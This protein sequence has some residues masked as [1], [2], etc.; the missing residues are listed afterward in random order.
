MLGGGVSACRPPPPDA[1]APLS[2]QRFLATK[3]EKEALETSLSA[4]QDAI[5]G[6]EAEARARAAEIEDLQASLA[7]SSQC[8]ADRAAHIVVLQGEL[9]Q[10]KEVRRAE[11]AAGR[12]GEGRG[13]PH[14][15][16]V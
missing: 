11:A 15:P 7:A 1:C 4:A 5:A 14:C 12:G 10:E 13:W 8:A 9:A 2:T 6:L 3:G 16:N